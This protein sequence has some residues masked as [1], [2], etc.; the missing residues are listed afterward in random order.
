VCLTAKPLH[1]WGAFPIGD[2]ERQAI[3]LEFTTHTPT[4]LHTSA[5]LSSPPTLVFA[6]RQQ[7][8]RPRRKADSPAFALFWGCISHPAPDV[9]QQHKDTCRLWRWFG[10][11]GTD[12][13]VNCWRRRGE[14]VHPMSPLIA[15]SCGRCR[16][17]Y[18][19]RRERPG[20]GSGGRE[21]GRGGKKRGGGLE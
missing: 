9:N 13:S 18:T 17:D 2:R 14:Q 11:Q 5:Q 1:L 4:R 12:L 10:G 3:S 8:S 6:S 7:H 21:R 15:K 16:V 20:V 19:Y